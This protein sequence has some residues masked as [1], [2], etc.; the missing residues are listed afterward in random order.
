M[1]DEQHIEDAV[2][3][4]ALQVRVGH[5]ALRRGGEV[6]VLTRGGSVVSAELGCERYVAV[7]VVCRLVLDIQV[8][9]VDGEPCVVVVE[10]SRVAAVDP[11]CGAWTEETPKEVGEVGSV[12]GAGELVLGC[13]SSQREQDD[14]VAGLPAS[15]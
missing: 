2:L 13:G 7:P 9:A 14:L 11:G 3:E 6:E 5:D 10:G 1:L 15:G 8:E 4:H 12:C